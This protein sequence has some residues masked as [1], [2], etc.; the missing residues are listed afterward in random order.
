L[1]VQHVIVINCDIRT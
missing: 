1:K